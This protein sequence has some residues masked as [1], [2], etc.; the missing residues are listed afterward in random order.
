LSGSLPISS[1]STDPAGMPLAK[2]CACDTASGTLSAA[3]LTPM[4]K[5]APTS[6]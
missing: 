2:A 4:K 1:P 6:V 3:R 5:V